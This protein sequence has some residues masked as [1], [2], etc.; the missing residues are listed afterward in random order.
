M[1]HAHERTYFFQK[2]QTD[3]RLNKNIVFPPVLADI[4]ASLQF[5][6]FEWITMEIQWD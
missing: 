1:V 6:T 2:P 3:K 5:I 4:H